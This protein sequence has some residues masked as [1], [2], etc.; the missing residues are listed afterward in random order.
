MI[1]GH[2]RRGQ[3]HGSNMDIFLVFEVADFVFEFLST[4][5]LKWRRLTPVKLGRKF[6]KET[7]TGFSKTTVQGR[8]T[9]RIHW[10]FIIF[11]SPTMDICSKRLFQ[12]TTMVPIYINIQAPLHPSIKARIG[13]PIVN[14]LTVRSSSTP[15]WET[16]II[17]TKLWRISPHSYPAAFERAQLT[18]NDY[19]LKS[20]ILNSYAQRRR[21]ARKA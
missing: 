15:N 11:P 2:L 10:H 13:I 1:L 19:Y 21:R 8:S 7:D 12:P 17:W 18:L 4:L 20:P 9:T 3:C 5:I 16:P 6:K 14:L